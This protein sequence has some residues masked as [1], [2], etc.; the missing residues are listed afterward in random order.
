MRI[1]VGLLTAIQSSM[2]A[3]LAGDRLLE[4]FWG[5]FLGS[6]HHNNMKYSRKILQTS[7]VHS[8]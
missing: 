7:R 5:Q 3:I 4:R 2:R 1:C 8:F 6:G